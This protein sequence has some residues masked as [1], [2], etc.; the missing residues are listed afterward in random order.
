MVGVHQT[1]QNN[2]ASRVDHL[3][4]SP[5]KVCRRTNGKNLTPLG[6]EPSVRYLTTHVV[7]RDE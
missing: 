6:E 5:G 7:H 1:R 2:H 4:R 3:I